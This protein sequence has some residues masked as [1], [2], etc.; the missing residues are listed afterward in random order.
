LSAA[1]GDYD[2]NVTSLTVEYDNEDGVEVMDTAYLVDGTASFSGQSFYIAADDSATI[3]VYAT[4]NSISSSG[5]TATAG[6][7]VDLSLAYN[8]FEAIAQGSGETYKADK[9]DA[10]VSTDSDLDFGTI[11]FTDADED[12]D[13]NTA[14]DVTLTLGST[15][16]LIIDDNSATDNTNKL[17]VGSML[18]VDDDDS[19]ACTTEDIYVVTSWPTGTGATDT[20]TVL[21]VDDAG[22]DNYDDN[23]PLLYSLPGTGFHTGTNQMV[24]YESMPTL[25]LSS[26]S[27]SGSRSV[28]ASDDAFVFTVTADSGEKIQVRP[29]VDF[30]TCVAGT[31]A[32][33]TSAARR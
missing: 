15:L 9:I 25:A 22:D 1:L 14:Q 30:A 17:P 12:F 2:N 10:S 28:S 23:D 20:V 31:G 4:L 7:F 26:S 27:P 24:V 11:T 33:L 21:A 13:L 19:A 6:E 18:C 5:S 32:T 16:T 29:S 8:N 3:T